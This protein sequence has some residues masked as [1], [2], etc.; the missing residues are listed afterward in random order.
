[1][2]DDAC[3]QPRRAKRKAA[4]AAF[5]GQCH[6]ASGLEVYRRVLTAFAL[7]FVADLLA[8]VEAG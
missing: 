4:E 8:L 7:D 5:P 6:Q 2:A 1:V 3:G